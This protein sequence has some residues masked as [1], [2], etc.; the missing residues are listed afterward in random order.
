MISVAVFSDQPILTKG[1]TALAAADPALHL[2]AVCST[3]T[4][5]KL[6]LENQSSEIVLLDL[7]PE[8]TL[9]VIRELQDLCP[10]SKL[11]LWSNAVDGNFALHA[12]TL[13]VRGVLRKTL[14]AEAHLQCLHRVS[15][16]ELWFEKS[17]TDSF[18]LARR[19]SL[20]RR[21]GQLVCLLVR[22]FKNKEISQ[23]LGVTEGTVKVYLSHLM[24]K[25]GAKDRFE[26]ALQGIKTLGVP[27]S[28]AAPQGVLSNLV[29]S[30]L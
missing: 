12:L 26:L 18:L 4:A 9:T 28:S 24:Q 15:T 5:L 1:L 23:E 13:G 20:S 10:Q 27:G 6:H 14:P 7:T 3:L 17:L 11:I 19:V 2:N 16:G 21:E 8:I 29:V 25:T 22:G 30:A